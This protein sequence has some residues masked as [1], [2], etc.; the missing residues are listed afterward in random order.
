MNTRI[1]RQLPG[2]D[3][4]AELLGADTFT[5]SSRGET[6]EDPDTPTMMILP[7]EKIE[8]SNRNPRTTKNNRFDEIKE[9]IKKLHGLITTLTVTRV[10]GETK[11]RLDAGG[12]TR[13]A[14]IKEAYEETHD[15]KLASLYVLFKPYGGETSILV[16]HLIENNL[17]SDN[18]F[19]EKAVAVHQAI[20]L[21]CQ[22]RGIEK[23]ALSPRKWIAMI[24]DEYGYTINRDA[25]LAYVYA[26]ER[27][28]QTIPTALSEGMGKPTVLKIQRLES[29]YRQ[30]CDENEIN[31]AVFVLHFESVLHQN[32][33]ESFNLE[34]FEEELLDTLGSQLDVSVSNGADNESD[35][36]ELQVKSSIQQGVVTQLDSTATTDREL[37]K[38]SPPV[39]PNRSITPPSKKPIKQPQHAPA[40]IKQNVLKRGIFDMAKEVVGPFGLAELITQTDHGFGFYIEYPDDRLKGDHQSVCWW[41]VFHL[42]ELLLATDPFVWLKQDSL[43]GVLMSEYAE[44][45][46]EGLYQKFSG[47]VGNP[48]DL[49]EWIPSLLTHPQISVTVLAKLLQDIQK[50]R[51]INTNLGGV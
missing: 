17:R 27:L 20:D 11:Y 16:N 6:V 23:S 25:Y 41:F 1:Q 45:G 31:D 2:D 49:S 32:D 8:F 22:E 26:L 9:S 19:H 24:N 15:E 47:T 4:L 18:T 13:L 46:K 40:S 38:I 10:P 7:L 29:V 43:L 34:K 36:Q 37:Q 44:K 50:V 35:Q 51:V 3:E 14:A 30:Y 28:S 12:N 39:K 33:D 21:L 5:S 48:S 42:S